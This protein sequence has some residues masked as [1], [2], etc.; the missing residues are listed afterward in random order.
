MIE[1]ILEKIYHLIIKN[2]KNPKFYALIVVVILALLIIFPYIDANFFY[3]ERVEKRVS[4][5]KDISEINV[6]A[7]QNDPVLK[8]EYDS[9][10]EEVRR[11]KYGNIENIMITTASE[12]TQKDKYISG[13]MYFWIL[14]VLCLFMKFGDDSDGDFVIKLILIPLLAL[15]G[16]FCGY[17]AQLIPIIIQPICNYILIP[18]VEIM[19]TFMLIFS[20]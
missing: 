4:I 13:G 15:F 18:V 5:L 19:G 1:K 12:E 11:Q 20:L 10:L 8:S 9:I 7:I 2:L 16:C 6:E 17:I 14:S 3:Y